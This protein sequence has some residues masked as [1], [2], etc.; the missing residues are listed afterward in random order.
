MGI[1]FDLI[2]R[3]AESRR[4]VLKTPH[5]TIQT[6][7]FMPVGTQGTVKSLTPDALKS[8]GAQ[9]ILANTYHLYLRP[10][11]QI[12]EKAGGLHRF[13]GWQG[14]ILTDSGGYQIFSLASLRTLSEQGVEFRS[15]IDG[16]LHLLT[17][18]K[19]VEIQ[20][21]LGS[22]IMMV[23]DEC[24][25]HDRPRDYM[26]RSVGLTQRWAKRCLDRHQS[27]QES[28]KD[29]GALFGIVQG[30]L[31]SDL[32]KRSAEGLME[33]D[34]P[35]YGIGGLSVGEKEEQFEEILSFTAPLLPG[36]RP[37]YLM[38]VGTPSDFLTAIRCGV[39]L[40]DCVMPTRAARNAAVFL[41]EGRVSI[42]KAQFK[43][44]HRPLDG[45][46]D[47]YCCRSFTRAYLRHLFVAKEMLA[48]TLATI[49][50]IRFFVR[51]MHQAARSIERGEF[52]SFIRKWDDYGGDDD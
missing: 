27:L 14:S 9:M 25:A 38:G 41:P 3:C 35:G 16:S 22:D 26:E 11:P 21:A 46:C 10:G 47:C 42:R 1:H 52:D 2:G 44:D 18:E 34:F 17:P 32:R 33:L 19:V 24:P 31:H 43:D 30:G 37:R 20:A 29:I 4:G 12:I 23:L 8:T 15:H 48:A 45:T 13:M 50:N 6:P 51:F 5:G 39:D 40:F 7:A 36:D 28:G 49:H